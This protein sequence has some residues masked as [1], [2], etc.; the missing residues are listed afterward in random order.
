MNISFLNQGMHLSKIE[1]KSFEDSQMR[2]SSALSS[3]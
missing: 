1:E 2:I 3:F